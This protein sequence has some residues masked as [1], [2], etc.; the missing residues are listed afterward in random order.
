VE[1][2]PRLTKVQKEKGKTSKK[3]KVSTAKQKRHCT[4]KRIELKRIKKQI[5]KIS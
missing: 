4:K 3:L 2:N 5:V 1:Q